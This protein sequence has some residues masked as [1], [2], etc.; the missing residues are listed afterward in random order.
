M[1]AAGG[2]GTG[3]RQRQQ[4]KGSRMPPICGVVKT[5]VLAFMKRRVINVADAT[6]FTLAYGCGCLKTFVESVMAALNLHGFRLAPVA[7][8]WPV[9]AA[10]TLVF[11]LAAGAARAGIVTL[12]D[13]NPNPNGGVV[14]GT[15]GIGNSGIGSVKVNG[16]SLLTV[17]RMFLGAAPAADGELT[18]SGAGSRTNV[19]WSAQGNLDVGSAGTGHIAVL[20]GATFTYGEATD[21]CVLNC[22]VFVSNGAGSTGTVQVDGFGSGFATPGTLVVGHK[23]VFTVAA[24]GFD[25]GTIGGTSRGT[26][27]V[28]GGASATAGILRIGSP[29]GGNGRTA[30]ERSFGDV[31]VDGAGSILNLVRGAALVGGQSILQLGAGG[32][33]NGALDIKNGGVV[34]L[35]GNSAATQFTGAVIGFGGTGSSAAVRVNGAGSRLEFSGPMG[36]I[37]LGQ[38]A[39]SSGELNITNGGFVGGMAGS[40]MPF[41]TVGRAGGTGALTIS[42]TDAAGHAS[43]LRMSGRSLFNDAGAFLTIGRREGALVGSGTVNVLAGGR[44]DIDTTAHVLTNGDGQPGMYLGF[45]DGASGTL[46][47]AGKS[48]L[49]GAASLMSITN[50]TGVNPYVAVGRDGATGNMTISGGGRF[51]MN[52][53]HVSVSPTYANGDAMFFE[54]GRRVDPGTA[55][56]LGTVTV[57]GAG[58]ELALTGASDRFIQVGF[59][60][61][62]TGTLNISNGGVVRSMS[63]LMGTGSTAFGA[64]NM[65]AGTLEL[66]GVRNA[67]PLPGIGAIL[68]LGRSG[69]VATANISN[70]SAVLLNS[71]ATSS[72]NLILG[73]TNLNPGGTGIMNVSSGSSVSVNAPEARIN[74]GSNGTATQTGL[75]I[76]NITG[77]GTSVSANGGNGRVLVGAD[78]NTV[79]TVFIGTGAALS[80]T[81][82]I[83]V[84]HNGTVNTAGLGTLVV[85]GTATAQNIIIGNGGFLGGSGHVVGTVNNHGVVNPG[86]SPGRLTI[87]G[88][89]DSSDG[90]IILEVFRR[91]DGTYAVDELVFGDPLHVNIGAANIEFSF[92]GDTDPGAFNASTL[93]GLKTFFKELDANGNVIDLPDADFDWFGGARFA[94][95]ADNY[96]FNS[97]SFTPHGGATLDAS[98]IPVAPTLAL[99]ALGLLGLRLGHSQRGARRA[100]GSASQ[101]MVLVA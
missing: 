18:V 54:I 66:A 92:L 64:L 87:D 48:A 75:G 98:R 15:L 57:T 81:S 95:R 11:L 84:A 89:F 13:V 56:S 41:V 17:G 24:D 49:T 10:V 22:R 16:G 70:G 14:A 51:V 31:V 68:S 39:N 77:A 91:A 59:G 26:V 45:G 46:N 86:N 72:T 58:S 83:G 40:D 69:G 6:L 63:V 79:G 93:F 36:F 30:A 61:D 52:S 27:S 23:S 67:G 101:P 62:S 60:S 2:E 35:D 44:L 9:A 96:T 74:V 99:V 85:N 8:M 71:T 47:I 37:N 100:Q 5:L 21:A 7:R 19:T 78:A 20:N 42:G 53:A 88:A 4:A 28:T 80:A 32:N 94:A 90:K 38:N 12:G 73:G 76:L 55:A 25:Y 50:S 65:N 43:Q 97:F 34:R 3:M 1:L 82:L 29:G 33:S